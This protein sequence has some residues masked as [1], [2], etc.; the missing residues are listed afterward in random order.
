MSIRANGIIQ[1]IVVRRVGDGF[2]IIA[3]RAAL[4]RGKAG[5][6]GACAGVGE[7][8]A[9]GVANL[10]CSRWRSSKTSSAK[11]STQSRR[12]RRI[13]VSLTNSI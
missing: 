5:G 11:I 8:D 4:A 10:R 2:Q 7:G 13:D 1:P 9:P 6:A 3:R 12:R